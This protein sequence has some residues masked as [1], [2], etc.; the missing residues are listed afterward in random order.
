MVVQSAEV[1]Q[2][3]QARVAAEQVRGR[4]RANAGSWTPGRTCV[5]LC[6][7]CSKDKVAGNVFV[8]IDTV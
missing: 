5:T 3:R 1:E 8:L 2:E 6:V 7:T 4:G